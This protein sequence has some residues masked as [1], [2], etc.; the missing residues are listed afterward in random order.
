MLKCRWRYHIRLKL[1]FLIE[2][3]KKRESDPTL[4]LVNGLF[5]DLT[6]Y[7]LSC[8]FLREHFSILRYDCRGQGGSPKP[9]SIYS[10]EDHVLDLK[11]LLEEINIDNIIL[12]G[13]SNGGRIAMEFS[14][15]FPK[16]VKAL[17]ALDTYDEATPM[18]AAK[19][20]SW[21]VAHEIGGPLHRFDVA[22]PW[23]WGEEFFNHKNELI[24]SYREKASGLKSHVVKGLIEG[25]LESF[26][27]LTKLEVQTLLVVGKEDLLTPVFNHEKMIAKIR[28]GKL[29]IVEGGHASVLERPNIMEKNILPWLM[30]VLK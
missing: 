13:L 12:L 9:E 3:I 25:A 17:V 15:R 6:S 30:E 27:D 19:L 7:D 2:G 29:L 18:L 16:M 22:T 20:N 10:L 1:N 21:K 23:I 8:V 26:I 5:A 4:V 24:L 28:N 14:I 11:N